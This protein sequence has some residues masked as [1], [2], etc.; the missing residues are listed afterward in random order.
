MGKGHDHE[1]REHLR[2]TLAAT[3]SAASPDAVERLAVYVQELT[4]WSRRMS[5]TTL[6]PIAIVDR[7]VQ[8]SLALAALPP[9]RSAAAVADLGS[10][11]GIPGV[12]LQIVAPRPRFVLIEARQRRAAFL[13]HIVRVCR[14]QGVEVVEGRAEAIVWA[15]EQRVDLVVCRAVAPAVT[16]LQ[17]CIGLVRLGGSVAIAAGGEAATESDLP[18]GWE[19]LPRGSSQAWA[20]LLYRRCST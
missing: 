14:L 19:A 2:H 8:P 12:P 6:D 9:Y 3:G 17:W 18:A 5:L 10:G 7:L 15:P 16:A 4:R 20:A 11:G 13:R 1:I